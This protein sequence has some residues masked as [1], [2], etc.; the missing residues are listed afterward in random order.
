MSKI[1]GKNPLLTP[2][3]EEEPVLT[4]EDVA[5]IRRNDPDNFITMS[6]KVRKTYLKKLRDY[7]YTN[8]IE[9]KSALDDALSAFLDGIDDSTLVPC[10]EK[11]KRTKK[12]V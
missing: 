1:L 5:I 12:E 11:P 6:F 3:V 2:A 7:A 9:I 4:E 10:P 8:R